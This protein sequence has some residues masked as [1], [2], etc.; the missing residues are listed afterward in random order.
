[1]FTG[2]LLQVVALDELREARDRLGAIEH[3][4][5]GD[6]RPLAFNLEL[7]GGD[8]DAVVVEHEGGRGGLALNDVAQARRGS[9]C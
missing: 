2:R 1:M 3:A 4:R 6:V 9:S 8:S 5:F 7:L